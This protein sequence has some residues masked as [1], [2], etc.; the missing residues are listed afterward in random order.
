VVRPLKRI[1]A[2]TIFHLLL[3]LNK[4]KIITD[5]TV[6]HG[7]VTQNL[8]RSHWGLSLGPGEEEEEEEEGA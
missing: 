8:E 1:G 2:N 3:Y 6:T 5:R 4:W 7:T